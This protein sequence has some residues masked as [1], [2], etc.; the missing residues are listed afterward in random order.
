MFPTRVRYTGASLGFQGASV[1]GGALAP[2]IATW[3]L[4]LSPAPWPIQ[5]YVILFLL[6]LIYCVYLA[7]ETAHKD[8]Q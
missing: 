8:L 4:G 6:L 3:L 7:R 2:I 1:F 5:L